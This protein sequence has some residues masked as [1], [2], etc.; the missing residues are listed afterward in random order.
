MM[1]GLCNPDSS[2]GVYA[3]RPEDYVNFSFYL[4]PLIRAYHNIEGD[5]KQSHDWNI[6]TGKYLLKDIKPDLDKVSM[7]ARVARN[8][9]G[10]NLPPSMDKEERLRFEAKME[11]VFA[12]F[13]IPGKYHS[14]TPG[15]KNQCSEADA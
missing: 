14:L 10:W 8:V 13:D 3:T 4:E 7:R 12:K 2:V 11:E 6:P 9:K 5:T 1:G 15:H